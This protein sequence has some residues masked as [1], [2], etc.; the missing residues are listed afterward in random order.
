MII[1]TDLHVGDNLFPDAHEFLILP[2]QANRFRRQDF[3]SRT[4]Q[5]YH[6]HNYIIQHV[7]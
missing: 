2:N 5:P 6:A 3:P 4:C 1:S 7:W